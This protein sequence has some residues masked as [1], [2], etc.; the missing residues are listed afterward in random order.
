MSAAE[1]MP[2]EIWHNPSCSQSRN[3]LAMIRHVGIEPRVVEYATASLSKARI[4]EVVAAAGLGVREAI[5]EKDALFVELGLAAPAVSDDDLLDAMAAHPMLINRPFVITPMGTRL[6]R[7]PERVLD[8]L[9]PCERPFA[10][11]NGEVVIDANGVRV[12]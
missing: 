8:L 2:V 9:P 1:T 3:A 4:A 12:R 7:P 6:C 11:E 10:K 5:R